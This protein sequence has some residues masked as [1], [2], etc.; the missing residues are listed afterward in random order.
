M[1][2]DVT[3]RGQDV[4]AQIAANQVAGNPMNN[5]LAG[6]QAEGVTADVETKKKNQALIDEV[7]NPATAPERKAAIM[8]A[9]GKG[10]KFAHAQGGTSIDPGTGLAIKTPDVIYNE[11]TGQPVN[12]A[13]Q[14]QSAQGSVPQA[15]VDMLKKN[16]KLAADFD[17]KYGAGAAKKILGV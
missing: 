14:A 2:G 6:A 11:R 17:K 8:S 16:P 12:A 13:P 3:K 15:A 10:D 4:H 9:I 7:L 1:Q 5:A